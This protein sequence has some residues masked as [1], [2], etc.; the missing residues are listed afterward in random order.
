MVAG[1]VLSSR[2]HIPDNLSPAY[3]GDRS[4]WA[5]SAT[6]PADHPEQRKAGGRGES[7]RKHLA[8]CLTLTSCRES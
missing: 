4:M 7:S 8:A 3:A 5:R 1:H 2:L 6:I